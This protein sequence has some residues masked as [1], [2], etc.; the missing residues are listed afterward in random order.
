MDHSLVVAKGLQH[1]VN[2]E[3]CLQS[4]PGWVGEETQVIMKRSDKTWS[5]RGANG[6]SLQCSCLENPINSKKRQK[7]RTL[8]DETPRSESVQYATG[9]EQRA[10]T[11]SS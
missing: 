10:A 9:E 7:D 1:S 4:N 11:N 6:Y 3:P 5:S 2:S 8:E